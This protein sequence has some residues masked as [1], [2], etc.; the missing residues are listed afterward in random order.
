MIFLKNI[1]TKIYLIDWGFARLN[2]Q[3]SWTPLDLRKL[4]LNYSEWK[5]KEIIITYSKLI[6]YSNDK[7]EKKN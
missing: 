7:I 4:F 5:I 1:K 2:L 3:E 6:K